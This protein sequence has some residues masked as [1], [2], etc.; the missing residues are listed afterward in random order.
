MMYGVLLLV[1]TLV[2]II[3]T[4]YNVV[5]GFTSIPKA[6]DWAISNFIQMKKR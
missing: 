1:L 4:K 3:I 6:I 5:K 2:A